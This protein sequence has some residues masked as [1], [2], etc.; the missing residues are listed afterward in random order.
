MKRWIRWVLA[1]LLVMSVACALLYFAVVPT[2]DMSYPLVPH[3][4]PP[5]WY[6]YVYAFLSEL[7]CRG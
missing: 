7:F 4:P 6:D 3:P 2:C 5:Q 1:T